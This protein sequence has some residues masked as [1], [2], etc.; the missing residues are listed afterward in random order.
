LG[1]FSVEGIYSE[2]PPYSCEFS[3]NFVAGLKYEFS[4]WRE[5]EK[6]GIFGTYKSPAKGGSFA[7]VPS[8][9]QDK[10]PIKAAQPPAF[11]PS[12]EQIVQLESMGFQNWMC[13]LALEST[14]SFQAAV[15]YCFTLLEGDS[16]SGGTP[17]SFESPS[18]SSVG[19][20]SM[21]DQ[22]VNL[23]FTKEQATKVSLKTVIISHTFFII[24]L[25]H[26]SLLKI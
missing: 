18:D 22:L 21:I 26:L 9:D 19:D 24:Y 2:K 25:S 17:S 7:F 15:D 12:E 20:S 10:S 23:G 6:G 16:S 8:K 14:T 4:G 13:K 11:T 3:F 1:F 5:S